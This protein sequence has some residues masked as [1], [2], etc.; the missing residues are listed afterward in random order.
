M[1]NEE[2]ELDGYKI[3]KGS[4]ILTPMYIMHRDK[5]FWSNADEFKPERWETQS[6]KEAG[7]KFIYFPFG[8]GIRR[9]IGE[10]FAWM[11]G[12]LLLAALGKKHKLKLSA[13]Q[14]IAMQPLITLRPK[15]GMKMQIEKR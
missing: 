9:C 10:Q 14:E 13:T 2:H 11:E 5:R 7:Q 4:L 6:V 15:F 12:V 8:G 1:A 3:A